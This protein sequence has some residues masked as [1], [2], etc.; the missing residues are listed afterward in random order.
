MY[1]DVKEYAMKCIII[2][3]EY[4][5]HIKP[6]VWGLSELGCESV[7]IPSLSH[8]DLFSLK[9]DCNH[10]VIKLKGVEISNQDIVWFRRIYNNLTKHPELEPTEENLTFV[11][12]EIMETW[13]NVIHALCD[14]SYW[15]CN[16]L[17]S[18]MRMDQKYHQLQQA[19][20]ANLR[21]PRTAF[22]NELEEVKLLNDDCDSLIYKS[23]T[24]FT[25]HD[26]ENLK[27]RRTRTF[28]I[29][30]EYL[31]D[32][33]YISSCPAIVQEKIDRKYDVRLFYFGGNMASIKI[34]PKE[35]IANEY[36]DLREAHYNGLCDVEETSIP[37]EIENKVHKFMKNA[38]LVMGAIDFS[39]DFKGNWY[40]L[41]V[42][43]QG[44]W[45]YME[46]ILPELN[47]LNRFCH[48]LLNK[49]DRYV[50]GELKKS[51]SYTKFLK[52]NC[53]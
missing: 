40:F 25:F 27:N 19:K 32:E 16:N 28:T 45:L 22:T 1:L 29:D 33:F 36:S 5:A 8:D 6:V 34:E 42:N 44:Q 43:T 4:D 24:P 9:I 48:F 49:S 23:H 37:N 39:V 7:V 46:E 21:F 53:S 3:S 51:F 50:E 10:E 14:L 26:E 47:L 18:Q 52:N 13:S 11:R 2:G 20:I 17:K 41:E 38:D 15:S 35:N 31:K 30:D 12:S